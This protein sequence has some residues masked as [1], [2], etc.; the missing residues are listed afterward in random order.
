MATDDL[1][2]LLSAA[3]HDAAE[4]A[5]SDD[6]LLTAVRRRS[7][8]YHRRR[9]A[10]MLSAVAAAVA[11]GIPGVAAFLLR[12]PPAPPTPATASLRLVEGYPAPTF[13]YTLPPTNGMK[14]PV[15]AVENDD[16]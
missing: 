15:A 8:R 6:G 1:D 9:V 11:V 4:R 3:L 2:R 5:P 10:T 13:P 7:G 14:A 16:L 12:P